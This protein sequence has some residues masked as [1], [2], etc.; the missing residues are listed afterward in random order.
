MAGASREASVAVDTGGTFTD[1]VWIERGRLRVLKVFSTPADPSE[2]I[3]E[4]VAQT[5][6]S[7]G[8]RLLH[9]TTVG[10]NTLLQRKGARIA[11]VTTAGFEDAIEIGRQ[12]RP[13]LY[14]FFFDRTAPLVSGEMRFGVEERVSSEGE[15]LRRPD[16]RALSLLVEKLAAAKPDAVAICLLFSFAAQEN[17]RA[18]ADALAPLGVPLSLSHQILPEFREYERMST[19]TVNAY[20]QPVMETYLRSLAMR[21]GEGSRKPKGG[22]RIFVMQ[23]SGGITSLATAAREPVR[24]VLSGPA[25]GV[26]GAAAM[27]RRSGFDH[28]I[29]FD[30]GGTS[31]DVSLVAGAAQTTNEADVA[32]LPV[33]VPMLDIHT[34]GA[35]GGSLARFDAA[36]ALRVGP[37]SA[38]ADPGPICY[39]RGEQP[40][41]TDAN[42][43]LGRLRPEAFLGGGFRLDLERTQKLVR[44]WLKRSGSSM[45]T[46]EFAAGAVRVVNA[47]ME[48][49]LRVVSIERGRDP[50]AFTL[51]AFGGAG[52]LHAC[53]LARAL[54]IPRVLVPAYPGALSALGILVSDVVKHYSRTVVWRAAAELPKRDLAAAFA[55]LEKQALADL[56]AEGWAGSPRLQRSVDVRYHGQ[57]FELNV[58]FTPRLL[59]DFHALHQQRYGYSHPAR[60]TELVTLRLRATV[61]SKMKLPRMA[62][63]ASGEPA[64]KAPVFFEGRPHAA[65][66]IARESLAVGRRMAG[67]A[68]VTEYSATTVIPP[69]C[70]FHLDGA[71]NLVIA[72][73]AR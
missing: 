71:G 72:V 62:P 13:R 66:N 68:I 64:G 19:V 65:G 23:S 18:V 57:G 24:T 25:G 29:G 9:G 21:L 14:D 27:A 11:L 38:G 39:G 60:E 50:R 48:K 63:R 30:M 6:V 43:L 53:E 8:V 32:G 16:A 12:H 2:S 37:E 51:V 45:T 3:A 52:P 58:P 5:R 36:G 17:E 44:A 61:P 42:L 47:N 46:E 54:G 49:A 26:V 1:C 20:L 59:A 69:G 15:V 41:V 31:T 7:G 33:R 22:E 55:T 56:R 40:T 34:V 67:P 4:A 70:R 73:P 28:I 35:G 10:T